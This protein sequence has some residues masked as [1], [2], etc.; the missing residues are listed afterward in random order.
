[1]RI[2]ESLA[3]EEIVFAGQPIALVVGETATAAE[4]AV[5]AV[6]VELEPLPAVLDL[7][8]A[9]VEGSPLA[10][11]TAEPEGRADMSLHAG[12]GRQGGDEETG[13]LPP[14]VTART[15]YRAG[16]AERDL[17]CCAHVVEGRFRSSWIHQ[18]YL[19]P[20]VSTAWLEPD[21]ELVVEAS[22]QGSFY[23]RQQLA[24]LLDRPVSS[25]RVVP[26]PLGGSFG[27]K[28]LVTEPLAAAAALVLRRPVRLA[29]TRSEDFLATQPAPATLLDVRVG[30][31]ENGKLLALAARLVIDTGAFADWSIDSF[32]AVL[33]AG[34]YEWPSYALESV[35]VRTN[36][37]PAGAYRGPGGP[38]TAFALE[39]LLDELCGKLDADPADLRHRNAASDGDEMVDG[40][41]WPAHGLRAC[42]D[43]AQ[44]HP[45]WKRRGR[46][47]EG[48]GIGLAAAC[49]PG[50]KESARAICRLDEDG[51]L[52]IVTGAVDMTGATTGLVAIAAD[53]FGIEP[54][55]VRVAV[56][57]TALAPH[58]P[59]GG[60][61]GFLYSLGNAVEQAAADAREQLLT[62][63][64]GHLE[65]DA[66]DLE[67]VDGKV[68][69]RGAPSR[70]EPLADVAA[71][72][73]GANSTSIPVQGHGGSAPPNVSPSTAVHVAHVRV[74]RETGRV[75][76]LEHL[77]AQD[78][79]RAISPALVEGQIHGGAAQGLGW[80][81]FEELVHDEH[82]NLVN[83]S[84]VDYG[85]PT[86]DVVPSFE[87]VVVEVPS[88]HGPLGAKGMAEAPVIAAPA[89][90]ANAVAAATGVRLRELPMSSER[91]WRASRG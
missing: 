28:Y 18:G 21:G 42:L 35:G 15:V 64:A 59:P 91:V 4:D 52:T 19:E 9:T 60:G 76:V 7:E 12:V 69:T 58:S 38:Q 55:N 8:N 61:S 25:I 22:Q 36:R 79:G 10:R 62:V 3:R 26:T 66:A 70:S 30:A 45:I 78:V 65:A 44:D 41:P 17:A 14:N 84:F 74:D 6:E 71:R 43:A 87:T 24:T 40:S 31:D 39:S 56:A 50:A 81:L 72:V 89:A 33:L 49:W 11:I 73:A 53:T 32:A 2:H 54:E 37:F 13:V 20:H 51:T 90:I 85:L 83:G 82:G 16:D 86:A 77:V 67:I 27:S 63:A 34:P 29:L 68:R 23:T 1:M 47:A 46:L 48:E 5:E 80:A 75:D 57:D 88:P